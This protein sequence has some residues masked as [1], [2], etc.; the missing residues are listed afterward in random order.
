[1][2]IGI[3]NVL[4]LFVF[5]LVASS[6]PVPIV[7]NLAEAP[8]GLGEPASNGDY[9][10]KNIQ[11]A[12]DLWSQTMDGN[13]HHHST[14]ELAQA[15]TMVIQATYSDLSN[16]PKLTS[17]YDSMRSELHQVMRGLI[18]MILLKKEGSVDPAVVSMALDTL[19]KYLQWEWNHKYGG[20]YI[21]KGG[22][23]PLNNHNYLEA[24]KTR[25]TE[26]INSARTVSPTRK[27]KASDGHGDPP[28]TRRLFLDLERKFDEGKH[29]NEVC[30]RGHV[31]G[32]GKVHY[33]MVM[34]EEGTGIV[35]YKSD[36]VVN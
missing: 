5:G 28:K 36:E 2:K 7:S 25:L 26:M 1:M 20:I 31:I 9:T 32:N 17:D 18:T 10:L 12:A 15:Q 13:L 21:T 30:V 8:S 16:D 14:T 4:S 34:R 35:N 22:P 11:S 3:L 23:R 29:D 24:L 19:Q 27:R 33:F 6:T